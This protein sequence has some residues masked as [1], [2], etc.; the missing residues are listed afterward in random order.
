MDESLD[1]AV[2]TGTKVT[3]H[4][5]NFPHAMALAIVSSTCPLVVN[6]LMPHEHKLSTLNFTCTRPL[7]IED[8]SL[9]ATDMVIKSKDAVL[10]CCGFRRFVTR[11]IYS[12]NTKGGTN[13]VHKFERFLQPGRTSI[14]TVYAP[15]QYS[16]APVLVFTSNQLRQSSLPKAEEPSSLVNLGSINLQIDSQGKTSNQIFN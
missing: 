12:T 9:F 14:G 7:V 10:L 13:N 15:V 2:S 5:D 8:N 4:L 3:V 16:P 11:P 6:T 1:S